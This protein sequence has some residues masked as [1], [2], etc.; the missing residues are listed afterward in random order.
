MQ[1]HV[2]WHGMLGEEGQLKP[3]VRQKGTVD[4][5]YLTGKQ[6]RKVRSFILGTKDSVGHYFPRG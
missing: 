6:W 1:N 3:H 4:G 5:D 2:L